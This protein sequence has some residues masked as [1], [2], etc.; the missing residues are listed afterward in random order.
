MGTSANAERREATR[1]RFN[2]TVELA[3]PDEPEGYEADAVDISIGGMSLKTAYLPDI[4]SELDCRFVLDSQEPRTVQA[5]GQVVWARD[6]GSESGAFG[7]RFTEL[8]KH[9]RVALEKHCEPNAA[10]AQQA[11]DD[12]V[13][14][15]LPKMAEPL[16]ARV[17]HEAEGA[18]VVGMDL[19]FIT[20]G[21]RVE[22]EG[23]KGKSKGKLE[24]V[25][26]DI[27]PAT[28]HARLVLTVIL[29]GANATGKHAAIVLPTPKAVTKAPAARAPIDEPVE[30]VT[31]VSRPKHKTAPSV[32]AAHVDE[33]LAASTQDDAPAADR[34]A[35][36][37]ELE[38]ADT[39]AIAAARPGTGTEVLSSADG[40][41][42][43]N[44]ARSESGESQAPSSLASRS[45]APAWLVSALER[46]RTTSKSAWAK[47]S[48]ALAKLFASIALVVGTLVA[49]V[50]AKITGKPVALPEAP[51]ASPN[52][53]T[54]AKAPSLAGVRPT[55]RKQNPGAEPVEAAESLT[56]LASTAPSVRRK[57]AM[58]GLAAF[59]VSAI[60]FALATSSRAPRPQTPRPQVAVESTPAATPA[61]TD[62]SATTAANTAAAPSNAAEP[63]MAEPAENAPTNSNRPAIQPA[64]QRRMPTDLVAA[65]RS[66]NANVDS[67]QPTVRRDAAITPATRAQRAQAQ[68]ATRA[69]PAGPV[70]PI[71]SPAVR[72][73]T[74][75]RLRLDGPITQLAGGA[76][77]SDS[78]SFRVAGRRVLDRAATFVRLDPR[79]AG[80]GAYNRGGNAEFTLRFHGA[81]PQFSARARG[82]V[83]EVT[84][85][86]PTT[87]VA[88]APR[89]S[90]AGV[91]V[92]SIPRPRR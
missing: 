54:T 53:R 66:R 19:S 69:E 71:G 92:A 8:S 67:E 81:A 55:L 11:K 16:K 72:T 63:T 57:Y 73:G 41:A 14:L 89:P 91:R 28:Q 20:L 90:A 45:S 21:E 12:R 68:V 29:D 26:V 34:H 13:R 75:L 35:H 18:V 51:K 74:T 40:A 38:N 82:D 3:M 10:S 5:R 87:R 22:V 59:G 9:D 52:E 64:A 70:R 50:R 32:H 1:R 86:A 23:V 43:A 17:Q 84:L 37:S 4:G 88:S 15:R 80:A 7:L 79:I 61:I 65:A 39:V 47:A 76:S 58:I 25:T 85:A 6:D 49:K 44:A 27:D 48:P 31:P 77:G 56:S 36:R 62:N 46:V 60:V 83:L 24:D 78:L 33:P 42:R 30:Q 2:G